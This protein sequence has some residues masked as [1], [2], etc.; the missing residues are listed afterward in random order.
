MTIK[1]YGCNV[2]HEPTKQVSNVDDVKDII[3][4]LWETVA[5][6]NG[7]GLSAN[8]LGYDVSVAVI[9]N[10]DDGDHFA[11][12][13]PVI[14]ETYGDAVGLKEG[15]LSLPGVVGNV[16]RH[17]SLKLKYTDTSG[18]PVESIFVGNTAH[19][20]QHEVEHLNGKTYIDNYGSVRKESMIKKHKRALKKVK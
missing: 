18:N 15:C 8:Q 11:I 3:K 19:I 1:L 7:A 6:V 13:N 16:K 17:L 20:I 9:N 4:E 14:V 2:L 5:E 10:V 12:I